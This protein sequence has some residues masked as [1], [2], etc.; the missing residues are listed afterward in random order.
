MIDPGQYFGISVFSSYPLSRGHVH[1]TG[2]NVDDAIDFV[3]PIYNDPDGF[4]LAVARWA[5][6]KQ[7]EIAR[8]M[9][10]YRGFVAMANPAFPDGSDAAASHEKEYPLPQDLKDIEYSK[11]DDAVLDKYLRA[12]AGSTWHPLGTCKMA[13]LES[14]GVVDASLSVYGVERLK[15]ADLSIP[16]SNVGSNTANTALL[17]GE[18][19]ADIL[20]EE[21]GLNKVSST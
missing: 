2:P 16:P 18:K 17:I 4:D 20:I 10:I 5:F 8:R 9:D 21:L 12:N 15:V 1:I 3:T 19:A 13:P 11:E 6:R 14:G 7:R